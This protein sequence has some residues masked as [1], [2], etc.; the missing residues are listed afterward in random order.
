[1]FIVFSEML[2]R[3]LVDEYNGDAAEFCIVQ[4]FVGGVWALPALYDFVLSFLRMNCQVWVMQSVQEN[5]NPGLSKTYITGLNT[6]LSAAA[7]FLFFG[8]H[9]SVQAVGGVALATLGTYLCTA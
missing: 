3:H 2:S 9:L 1:M 6:C 8:S 4:R 7:G 5:S